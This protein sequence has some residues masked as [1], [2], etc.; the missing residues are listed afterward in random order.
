MTNDM[1]KKIDHINIVVRDLYA[2]KKFFLELGFTVVH[3]G[4]LTGSWI[5]TI[6]SLEN[7]KAEYCSL[8]LESAQT[9]LELIRYDSPEDDSAQTK[10]LPNHHG[11]RHLAFEVADI[12][13][14]VAQLK[15]KGITLFS[16]I[17]EYE[18]S[19]KKL[20]YFYGPEGIILEL[21][22]YSKSRHPDRT[23]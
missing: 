19:K 2:A 20:C 18:P 17:Q 6:T 1:L 22:E 3:E 9:K 4:T 15:K 10:S 7:V 14:V 21:A 13:A 5:D 11:F 23:K 16:E 12:K 8:G